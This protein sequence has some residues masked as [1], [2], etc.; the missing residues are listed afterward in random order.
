[1]NMLRDNLLVSLKFPTEST[2]LNKQPRQYTTLEGISKI[3]SIVC[4]GKYVHLVI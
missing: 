3:R 1:M 2:N 4:V